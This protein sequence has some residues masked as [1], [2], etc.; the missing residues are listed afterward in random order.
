MVLKHKHVRVCVPEHN[1]RLA[2][3]RQLARAAAPQHAVPRAAVTAGAALV[4]AHGG[5][6]GWA[7]VQAALRKGLARAAQRCAPRQARQH[8]LT[9]GSFT[10]RHALQTRHFV[11]RYATSC[12]GH[13]PQQSHAKISAGGE[14]MVTTRTVHQPPTRWALPLR[15]HER[16]QQA[17][18]R[19]DVLFETKKSESKTPRACACARLRT[20]CCVNSVRRPL[21]CAALQ[22]ANTR[23]SFSSV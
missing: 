13:S 4:P 11:Q 22:G 7:A 14:A 16:P 17:S 8:G 1:A 5:R 3:R 12:T 10:C 19:V 6:G 21:R 9:A 23:R 18:G 2:Q 15:Q 20:L